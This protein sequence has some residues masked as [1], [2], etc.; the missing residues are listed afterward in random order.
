[1]NKLLAMPAVRLRNALLLS[2]FAVISVILSAAYLI[3]FIKGNRSEVYVAVYITILLVMMIAYSVAFMFM[4]DT[5]TKFAYFTF[6]LYS[7]FHLFTMMTSPYIITFCY[8]FPM[9]LL[10]MM[11]NSKK[12]SIIVTGMA[13]V[14]TIV[15]CVYHYFTDDTFSLTEAEISIACILLVTVFMRLGQVPILQ[16]LSR[17]EKLE[18]ELLIDTL[19]KCWNRKF[20]DN[21]IEHGFF[22][23]KNVS[24]ILGDI[25]NFK[26]IN[27]TLGH[28]QGDVVLIRVGKQLKRICDLYD[29]TWEIRIGGDEFIVVTKQKD[30][31]SLMKEL[32]VACNEDEMIRNMDIDVKVAFGKCSNVSGRLSYYEMYEI[33]DQEMYDRKEEMKNG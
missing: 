19:T 33:A 9:L 21:L 13:S 11:Y 14:N 27:D 3:E 4:Q 2:G 29:D 23:S 26:S 8:I 22:K 12:L 28:T 17:M 32:Y 31:S 15:S 25:N 6:T 10:G 18:K 16:N 7:I 24:V 20:L 30:V 5:E 1:M